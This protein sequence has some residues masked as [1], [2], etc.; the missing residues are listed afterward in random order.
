MAG[1]SR[2]ASSFSL[3][4]DSPLVSPWDLQLMA[5]KQKITR[6]PKLK[7][8]SDVASPMPRSQRP[9][10]RYR[11]IGFVLPV[12]LLLFV[13]GFAGIYSKWWGS[14]TVD[15]VSPGVY[16]IEVVREFPHDPQ[17][18]TQVFA[19]ISR[20]IV[21]LISGKLWCCRLNLTLTGLFSSSDSPFAAFSLR[22]IFSV[23]LSF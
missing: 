18:F 5:A 2:S 23:R 17:A 16:S 15:D 9:D 10:S 11:R 1:E 22:K 14:F 20:W 8:D 7:P 6:R 4:I 13:V 3:A 12:F 21:L 19:L